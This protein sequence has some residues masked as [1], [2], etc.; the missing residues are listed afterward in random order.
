[1]QKERVSDLLNAVQSRS[2]L[3]SAYIIALFYRV[4]ATVL[5]HGRDLN[6]GSVGAS[7]YKRVEEEGG[8]YL[9]TFYRSESLGID[10]KSERR[11]ALSRVVIL[12][13]AALSHAYPAVY[14]RSFTVYYPIISL[15]SRY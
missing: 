14:Y 7:V 11:G 8:F 6:R 13:A 3:H 10:V 9:L 4:F 1:M 15:S 12:A 5:C 2:Y